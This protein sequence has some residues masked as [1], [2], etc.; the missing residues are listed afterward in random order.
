MRLPTPLLL[1]A[2]VAWSA[3]AARAD[4]KLHPLFTDNMVVHQA[5]VTL[6]QGT[7]EPG[8]KV[9]VTI[10][11]VPGTTAHPTADAKGNWVAPLPAMKPGTGY[12][13]TATGKSGKVELKNVAVGEV[14]V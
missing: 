8:E 4:V 5:V 1:I 6:V 10:S 3:P 14:W 7:A 2:A 12:T 13:L 11:A 9:D